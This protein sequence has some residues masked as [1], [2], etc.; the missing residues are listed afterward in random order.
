VAIAVAQDIANPSGVLSSSSSTTH[1]I[2]ITPS[3][4]SALALFFQWWA[5]T[6]AT[7]TQVTDDQG[8]SWTVLDHGFVSAG[9][10]KGATAYMQNATAATRVITITLSVAAGF[11]GARV[12][13][14][15]G[16]KTSGVLDGHA[17]NPQS[18]IGTTADALTSG[19][20]T[21]SGAPA[22]VVGFCLEDNNSLSINA[23]TGFT[24]GTQTWQSDSQTTKS[25]WKRVTS[26]TS[27]AATFTN[28]GPGATHFTSFGLVFLEAADAPVL[29]R[30]VLGMGWQEVDET[31]YVR[32]RRLV[33]DGAVVASTVLRRRPP[34]DWPEEPAPP[35]PRRRARPIGVGESAGLP[36]VP[37]LQLWLRADLGVDITGGSVQ[38]WKDQ[39]GH[40][41]NDTASTLVALPVSSINGRAGFR[42]TGS[43]YFTGGTNI[44]AGNS[45][46]TIFAVHKP[47]TTSGSV[48]TL[49]T[50][51]L[52]AD[53]M[54][55]WAPFPGLV[56]TDGVNN[57]NNA[58]V[59]PHTITGQPT[60]SQWSSAGP[61][62][63]LG[64]K[65]NGITFAVTQTSGSSTDSGST[66]FNVGGG[67]AALAN[68]QGDI[69]EILVYD[70]VLS[71][72]DEAAVQDY[73]AVR[74]A[75]AT[76]DV[77]LRPR[78]VLGLGWQEVDDTT[79]V[80]R[81]L[82]VPQ[83]AAA[84]TVL[85]RRQLHQ[86]FVEEE[87]WQRRAPELP[88]SN[89]AAADFVL[90][91]RRR[92]FLEEEPWDGW[93]RR[94]LPIAYVVPPDSGLRPP[95]WALIDDHP[96]TVT[97]TDGP[98]TADDSTPARTVTPDE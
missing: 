12:V 92:Y 11:K 44:L 72:G 76:S 97:C 62:T 28:A 8:G 2:T 18:G 1:T 10:D 58:F 53:Y 83:G 66:G 3:A 88:V 64:Y 91:R 27:Q 45:P 25:E 42:L 81:R 22:M 57:P 50:S 95:L 43:E 15:T 29:K 82:L 4:G 31:T 6:G 84:D 60:I 38:G 94:R 67:G 79:Y 32:R 49:R 7:V 48:L 21:T 46:R 61:G 86:L 35:Q 52:K 63:V 77:Q 56:Y 71:A 98:L 78:R 96:N 13:E 24:G 30:R 36:A 69:C 59:T 19:P 93:R 34:T 41:L 5:Q 65:E 87:I 16:A 26:G 47:S 75:I 39:S 80:R 73:L 90:V 40:S 70:S 55:N 23:G 14:I 9:S 17:V 89:V 33:V 51:T 54:F 74:Y 68:Y 20:M 85:K 37:G